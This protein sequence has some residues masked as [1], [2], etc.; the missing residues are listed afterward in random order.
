[1]DKTL[2]LIRDEEGSTKSTSHFSSQVRGKELSYY[3]LLY[4]NFPTLSHSS[5]AFGSYMIIGMH[6][7]LNIGFK[8]KTTYFKHKG[9]SPRT[10]VYLVQSKTNIYILFSKLTHQAQVQFPY[11]LQCKPKRMVKET[12][13]WTFHQAQIVKRV[14]ASK[15]NE[16]APKVCGLKATFHLRSFLFVLKQ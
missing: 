10:L 4:R 1:M 14:K 5:M 16:M 7:K 11:K 13:L 12:L 6:E 15:R 9:K 8:P 2:A 3:L